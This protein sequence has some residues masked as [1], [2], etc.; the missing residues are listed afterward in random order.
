MSMIE[1]LVTVIILA[2]GLLGLAG[3]QLRVQNNEMESYQRAQALVLL[4]DMAERITANRANAANYVSANTI[5][6]GDAQ[7][8][9][10]SALAAGAPRD[11]CEWSNALK[12]AAE[13]SGTNQ[14][15]AMIGARGCIT[16]IQA[17]NNA[18]G[19]C[20]PGIY[21]IA[22]VWQGMTSTSAPNKTCGQ[23]LYGA[24]S[25]RRLVSAQVAAGTPSCS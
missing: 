12:G 9:D 10:C 21:E 1:V 23:N 11:L 24:D 4:N 20:T 2:L 18:A 15:G 19:V 25:L 13:V 16:Q 17:Q 14:V 22:V 5:G 7:P 8:A 6:T 3:L